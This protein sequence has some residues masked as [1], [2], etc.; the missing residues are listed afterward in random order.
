M[1][2][3]L[4]DIHLVLASLSKQSDEQKAELYELRKRLTDFHED[5]IGR[6][7]GGSGGEQPYS[8]SSALSRDEMD[9]EASS[10][11]DQPI[12]NRRSSNDRK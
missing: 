6:Y 10:I 9:S 1:I 3:T 2:K 4:R 5:T 12:Q 11:I 8:N 7:L